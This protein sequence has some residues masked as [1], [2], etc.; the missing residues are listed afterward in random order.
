MQ[1]N[2]PLAFA[3]VTMAGLCTTIGASFACCF[4]KANKRVLAASLGVSAG[5]MLFISFVEILSIKAVEGFADAGYSDAHAYLFA[6]IAF[7][8]GI[9]ITMVLDFFVH[10]LMAGQEVP[11]HDHGHGHDHGGSN[12]TVA[13]KESVGDVEFGVTIR[14]NPYGKGAG[15]PTPAA[16]VKP[17]KDKTH[18]FITERSVTGGTSDT[19]L[20]QM[21]LITGLAIA[22]HNLPEGLATFVLPLLILISVS[23]LPS[24]SHFTI[25]PKASASQCRSSTQQDRESKASSGPSCRV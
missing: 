24:P 5:V 25:S 14:E 11:G 3:L 16:Y 9:A 6:N 15:E 23:Q 4:D 13:G 10:K 2:V 17:T 19:E 7:F 18:S 1:E 12:P 22:L 21:G 20:K 8:C